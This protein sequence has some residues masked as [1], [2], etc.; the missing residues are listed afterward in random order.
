MSVVLV[1][2]AKKLG[3]ANLASGRHEIS[4]LNDGSIELNGTVFWKPKAS[5]VKVPQKQ[6]KRA[7]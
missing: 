7:G 6:S 4:I 2:L 1:D 3:D 5:T